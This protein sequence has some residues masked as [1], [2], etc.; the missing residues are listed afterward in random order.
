MVSKQ[1]SLPD[2]LVLGLVLAVL[3]TA[4]VGTIWAY[5]DLLTDFLTWLDD[6][7]PDPDNYP[8]DTEVSNRESR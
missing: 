7:D 3:V 8:T 5:H 6:D 1:E 4:L 2:W